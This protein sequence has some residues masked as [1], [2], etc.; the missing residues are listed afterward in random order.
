MTARV[1]RRALVILVI[2]V[3]AFLGL[4]MAAPGAAAHPLGN[5]TINSYSG[6]VVQPDSVA[7]QL[8]VDSAEIPTIQEFPD[9]DG[10]GVSDADAAAYAAED[11]DRAARGLALTLDGAREPLTVTSADLTFLPGQ[12]GLATMRLECQ[13]ETSTVLDPTG[14]VLEYVDR[15]SLD[16]TGWREITLAGDGVTLADSTAASDSVSGALRSYPADLLASPLDQR[17]A[18]AEIT[19]GSGVASRALPEVSGVVESSGTDMG[20]ITETF[21]DLVSAR[22]LGPGFAAF[23]LGLSILLGALHAFA[24]GHGKT[25]MAAYLLGRRGSLRQVGIIGLTVTLTHTAGV[26]VLGVVLSTVAFIAP[27]RVYGWLGLAS[28]VL[29]VAIGATLLRQALR[30]SHEQP[31]TRT[32]ELA[33][34]ATGA[35]SFAGPVHQREQQQHDHGHDHGHGHGHGHEGET[36]AGG[37]RHSHGWGGNHTHP[38]PATSL[39]G[40]IGVGFAG[41]M[42]PSPSAL[43]V[44]LG[45]IALGRAWFGVLL[46][47][48]YGIG[49]A[50]ALIGTGLVL[51][52]SR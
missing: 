9:V 31:P 45:G 22:N 20:L 43:I 39:R 14:A 17:S 51:A 37:V 34:V 4:L 13:L 49:M 28:G 11:C 33:A 6:V 24:P 15:N 36:G 50:L 32:A 46:V 40:L 47:L 12:A 30:R 7:V 19:A 3:T 27:E 10:E 52:R 38:A 44:L 2:L 35:G 42:V 8:V 23:A 29:L 5:F 18:S 1:L 16:R 25:L 21:T 26:L 41:G 48:G